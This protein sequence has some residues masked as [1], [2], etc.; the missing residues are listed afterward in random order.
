MSTGETSAKSKP[1]WLRRLYAW[2]LHWAEHPKAVPALFFISLIESSV[3]PIPPDPL[4]MT[5]CFT[6]PKNWVSLAFWCTVGSVIGAVV[7]WVLG[8]LFWESLKDFFFTYVPKFSP[9][10]FDLA[11][12]YFD[13]NAFLWILASAFTPIPFK[14]FTIAA[15]VFNVSL[16]VLVCASIF[17]RGARFFL[18]ALVIRICGPTARP[19][20][21]KYLEIAAVAFFVLGLLGFYALKWLR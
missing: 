15:G 11:K 14:V 12:G 7:G 16:W 2:T 5:I 6:R 18:V 8:W 10:V 21:E 20:L 17:G 3:F 4:L 9:E 1:N 13:Q 19:Y